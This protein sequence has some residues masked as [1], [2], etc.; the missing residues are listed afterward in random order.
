M[1]S[2]QES[3]IGSICEIKS[4]ANDLLAVGVIGV[5]DE[6][7][8]T[9]D[10]LPQEGEA[11]MTLPYNTPVKLVTYLPKLGFRLLLGRVYLSSGTFLRLVDINAEQTNER[12]QYFRLNIDRKADLIIPSKKEHETDE[13]EGEEITVDVKDV[14]LGGIRIVSKR[15]FAPDDEFLATFTLIEKRLEMM[16]KVRREIPSDFLR[17]GEHQYGCN[18]INVAERQLDRLC[19]ELFE[20][21]RLQIRQ[22]KRHNF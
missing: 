20:L 13:Q 1:H 6:E 15:I 2:Q 9:L 11:L 10:V 17:A 22:K 19:G 5:M 18:F 7:E 16:C 3:F 12:R 21:Q 14:S 8:N 4:L